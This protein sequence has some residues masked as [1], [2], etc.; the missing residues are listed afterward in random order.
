MLVNVYG[1]GSVEIIRNFHLHLELRQRAF[2][3]TPIHLRIVVS[4]A[5]KFLSK[6]GYLLFF[7]LLAVLIQEYTTADRLYLCLLYT[8]DAA[9]D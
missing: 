9:D 6:T 7:D 4:I 2:H 5:F 1:I 3:I 8:S